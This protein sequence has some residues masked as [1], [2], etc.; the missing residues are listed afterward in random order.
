MRPRAFPTSHP[1]SVLTTGALTS[2]EPMIEVMDRRRG[3]VPT[4]QSH[5]HSISIHSDSSGR[6]SPRS[7]SD[8]MG[9]QTANSDHQSIPPN[10]TSLTGGGYTSS[11]L[12]NHVIQPPGGAIESYPPIANP[13]ITQ[14]HPTG[15]LDSHGHLGV[16]TSTGQPFDSVSFNHANFNFSAGQNGWNGLGNLDSAP[17]N[18]GHVN[19]PLAGPVY[20]TA[21]HPRVDVSVQG[22]HPLPHSQGFSGPSVSGFPVNDSQAGEVGFDWLNWLSTANV[23]MMAPE[24]PLASM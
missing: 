5:S 8:V 18:S 10:V 22:N 6:P 2:T 24:D 23:T 11:P 16:P 9:S 12:Q 3:F 7:S 15:S 13:P 14:S 19:A 4:S 20:D 1:D 21:I 17:L